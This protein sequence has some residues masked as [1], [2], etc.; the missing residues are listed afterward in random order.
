MYSDFFHSGSS[1][2]E[3]YE[4]FTELN[5]KQ[6][7]YK[8][9]Q[10]RFSNDFDNEIDPDVHYYN[11]IDFGCQY[12]SDFEFNNSDFNKDNFYVIHFNARSFVK[13]SFTKIEDYLLDLNC[14]FD[15]I[16]ISETWFDVNID[17][18][19]FK[20]NGYTCFY[21]NRQIKRVVV[22]PFLLRVCLML[23]RLI[24]VLCQLMICM[25]A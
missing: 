18:D 16:M 20:L 21:T 14:Y 15:V 2:Y 12:F 22:L 9:A 1:I 11:N 25:N 7:S 17:I 10:R 4:K 24:S 8:H 5:V 23:K 13:K 6:F 3:L 19:S